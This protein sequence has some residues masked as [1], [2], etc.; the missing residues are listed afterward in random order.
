MPTPTPATSSSK[1]QTPPRPR[2]RMASLFNKIR[3]AIYGSVLLFTVICLA[4]AAH[5]QTVLAASDLTRFVPFAI[6]VCSASLFIF[7]VLLVF[8][9]FLRER[10]PISTRI[11]LASL[12]LA[13][14]FWLVLG[15]FLATSDSQ[16][17]DVE[18]FASDTSTEPL[19]S[20]MASFHTD[21]YQ[22]MYRVLNAFSL[23]NATLILLS[24][25][26]LLFLAVR[27]HRKG[28]EHMWY[29]PVT[30][31]AWFNSYGNA[32]SPARSKSLK[33]ARASILPT[34]IANMA[35]V[36]R[37]ATKEDAYTRPSRREFSEKPPK[38]YPK[39]HKSRAQDKHPRQGSGDS[40]VH[41]SSSSDFEN[42]AMLNPYGRATRGSR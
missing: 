24:C 30:S 16:S 20:S 29:G 7:V 23:I 37:S 33:N 5:F 22:A 28:D 3:A 18:C 13:G 31:C 1:N 6:F 35:A 25:F 39:A 15:V 10:N 34:S 42:G 9:F 27:K 4:M 36:K 26:I 38:P 11:E 21:Q 40:S 14:M 2:K 17:A 32:K 41:G 8:S 19:D 12:G